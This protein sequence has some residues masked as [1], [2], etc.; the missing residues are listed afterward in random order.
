VSTL[1]V[2]LSYRTAALSLLERAALGPDAARTLEDGLR[3]SDHVAESVVLSTCNRLEVYAE[4]SRFHAG[5]V[6]IGERLAAATGVPL[7]ELTDH[8]YVHYEVAAVAH[9]F[10]VSCG[11]DSMAVGEQQ[12]LGQV[13]TAL[14]EGQD[15]GS[16]GRSLGPLLQQ[17]LRVGKQAHSET[18]LDRAG[19]SLVEAGL[20]E[21]ATV[22]GALSD[23]RALVLGA[24]AMSGLAVA[25]LGRAG[26]GDLAVA[27]RTLDRAQ[28]LAE[29][30]GGRVV[31]LERLAEALAEADLVLSC[32]GALGHLVA[33]VD[34]K[35]ALEARDGRPQVYLDLALPRDI[36][37]EVAALDGATLID[38]ERLGRVLAGQPIGADLAE[39]RSL[40]AAEVSGYLATQQAESVAPTVVAL[41]AHARSV[42]DCEVELLRG[43]LGAAV[44]ERVL[45]ELEQTVHRVVEKLLHTPTVR[46]KEL[47]SEPGAGSYAEALREL[48]GLD[49]GRVAAVSAVGDPAGAS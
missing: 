36:D 13:R 12:I 39:V 18:G 26:V 14:R 19:G 24:G 22:L 37:P 44:D 2:G 17:A 7:A 20:A 28:R 1:V 46:V 9:L 29:S 41:R 33:A 4:V 25:T 32:T 42:V 16:V 3:R 45:G 11:L 30:A 23:V 40:I 15:A 10:T 49:L 35:A 31:R 8:L 21:A 47:A 43:R 48:F 34:A 6:E 38:L 27:N 5:V